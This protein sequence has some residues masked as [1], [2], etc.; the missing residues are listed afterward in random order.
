MFSFQAESNL[1]TKGV[2]AM[3]NSSKPN[4]TVKETLNTINSITDDDLKAKIIENI[5]KNMQ[6]KGIDHATLKRRLGKKYDV[7]GFNSYFP[8][9][10]DTENVRTFNLAHFIVIAQELEMSLDDL[11]CG[12]KYCSNQ[13]VTDETI[14]ARNNVFPKEFFDLL[15]RNNKSYFYDMSKNLHKEVFQ[16]LADKYYCYYHSTNKHETRDLIE[17][18]LNIDKTG[19]LC[20]VNFKIGTRIAY[21][22][23]NNETVIDEKNYKGYLIVSNKLH[24]CFCILFGIE[25][26]E[27]SVFIFKQLITTGNPM[28]CRMAELLTV[29]AGTKKYPTVT[30]LLLSRTKL[31][32]SHLRAV[33]PCLKMNSSRIC[34]SS[35]ELLKMLED[36]QINPD[37]RVILDNCTK[38]K[39]CGENEIYSIGEDMIRSIGKELFGGDS[40]HNEMI[41]N[42]II[43]LR[44]KSISE[45]Y[46][47]IND[48]ADEAV[49]QLL[50]SFDLYSGTNTEKKSVK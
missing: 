10:S 17:A 7:D 45:R 9:K 1:F 18:E 30:R 27:I 11:L 29:S 19:D 47:K 38:V 41:L 31:D 43:Y 3:S 22:E 37:W 24:C 32:Q 34:I 4:S 40:A 26:S 33:A 20:E 46:N 50:Y 23:D 42:L 35:S 49:R 8:A 5:R 25:V 39:P 12:T 15:L 2:F 28:D 16:N 48:E 44:T 14:N 13:G 21:T 6:E 36:N